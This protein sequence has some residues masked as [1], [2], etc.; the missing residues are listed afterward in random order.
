MVEVACAL[1]VH[2]V[3]ALLLSD[4]LAAG[5]RIAVD[6]LRIT[7]ARIEVA[8]RCVLTSASCPVCRTTL[9]AQR[10]LV[11]DARRSG[12]TPHPYNWAAFVAS[13]AG[14]GLDGG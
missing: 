1:L 8:L 4:L 6:S 3:D 14:T 7:P 10:Q 5:D 12:G 2:G 13:G 9:A 11:A